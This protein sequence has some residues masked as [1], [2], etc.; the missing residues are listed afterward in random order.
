[1]FPGFHNSILCKGGAISFTVVGWDNCWKLQ[2][3]VFK[4]VYFCSSAS[5]GSVT[6]AGTQG[7]VG[8]SASSST[9]V[10]FVE[11]LGACRGI[12]N[13]LACKVEQN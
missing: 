6:A 9:D 10:V 3:Q 5:G 11:Q 8:V 2:D 13:T 12:H 7:G 1:M 4:V